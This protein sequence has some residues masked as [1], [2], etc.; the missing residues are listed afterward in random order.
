MAAASARSS[1]WRS[2][3]RSGAATSQ[4]RRK[5]PTAT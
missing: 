4:P 2:T 3:R 5:R 1:R